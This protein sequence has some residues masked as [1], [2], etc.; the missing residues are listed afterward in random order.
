MDGSVVVDAS[1]WVARL[2]PQDIFHDPCRAWLEAQRGRNVWLVSPTLLLAEVGGAIS[3]RTSEPHLGERA[4]E[5][6]KN[7]PVLR[8]VEMDHRLVQ[9]AVDLAVRL[10][11]RGADSFYVAVAHTLELP[12]ATLDEDQRSRA[13]S[14]VMVVEIM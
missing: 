11:L 13:E 6:L 2:I 3:R 9:V 10:G 1:I 4:A 14:L 8:L 7:L 12:L 5:V